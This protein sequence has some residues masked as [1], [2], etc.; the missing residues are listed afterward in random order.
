MRGGPSE[1]K[2][3]RWLI[4]AALSSHL[5][6]GCA[7]QHA[8]ELEPR[9]GSCAAE[10]PGKRDDGSL[11]S[12]YGPVD[13]GDRETLHEWCATVGPVAI[14]S[15]PGEQ[16]GVWRAVDS[17]AVVTWNVKVGGGDL[18][19]FIEHELYLSCDEGE[20]APADGFSHF[21][22][23]L[24]EAHRRSEHVPKLPSSHSI[25]RRIVPDPRPGE[26]VDVVEAARRCGLSFIYLPSMR[27][28]R[29]EHGSKREDKGSAILS[30]LPLN[31]FIA[32]ELPF[33]A[34][35]RVA[36]A[37]TVQRPDGDGPRVLSLH[38]DVS[39]TLFRTFRTGNST[40]VRQ[41]LGLVD[42]L[43]ILERTRPAPLATVVGGDFNTWSASE[44]VLQRLREHFPESPAWDGKPTRGAFP[45]DH[46]L[47]RQAGAGRIE[48]IDGS[49]RRVEDPYY[50]DHRARMGWFKLGG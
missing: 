3:S 44:T 9:G 48:F 39:S 8:M 23:L 5:S 43:R 36:V 10:A 4:W 42:A 18:L 13:L 27:N 38:L 31:D 22:L 35:R 17:L 25:P 26:H 15:L 46:L 30:T 37:A 29:E 16:F 41:G 34:A 49:Y 12:W 2:R 50:S 11:V 33:E 28:G 21:V 6:S 32:I 14:D 1:G 45:T 24:Q 20:P 19:G 7:M 47:F 40:R